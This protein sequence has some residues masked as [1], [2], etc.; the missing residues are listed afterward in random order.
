MP[1]VF[2]KLEAE[3]IPLFRYGFIPFGCLAE[4]VDACGIF[5]YLMGS[6]GSMSSMGLMGS[7][8]LWVL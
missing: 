7:M 8:G 4:L 5:A 2:A 3:A 1:D 6:L